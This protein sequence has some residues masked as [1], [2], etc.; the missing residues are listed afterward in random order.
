MKHEM[1]SFEVWFK[2]RINNQ[3]IRLVDSFLS[4][5]IPESSQSTPRNPRILDLSVQNQVFSHIVN[6]PSGTS[7]R[8]SLSSS[9]SQSE[10]NDLEDPQEATP[11][12][13]EIPELP[14]DCLT[15]V[16]LTPTVIHQDPQRNSVTR[17]IKTTKESV[18]YVQCPL[19]QS[20]LHS[21][22]NE[23]SITIDQ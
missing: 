4:N 2:W 8:P 9:E 14:E 20:Q 5:H 1:V 13:P 15:N 11:A 7:Q 17:A 10:V 18:V 12:E 16:P 21:G 3:D 23:S 6:L 22:D 19:P